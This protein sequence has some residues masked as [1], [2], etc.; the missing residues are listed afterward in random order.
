MFEAAFDLCQP[1]PLVLSILSPG[2]EQSSALPYST[3]REQGLSL[4]HFTRWLWAGSGGGGI[5]H[6][7]NGYEGCKGGCN[8]RSL[9]TRTHRRQAEHAVIRSCSG[10]MFRIQALCPALSPGKN[11]PTSAKA[12]NSLLLSTD[13]LATLSLVGS[14][15]RVGARVGLSVRQAARARPGVVATRVVLL[16]VEAREQANP[17]AFPPATPSISICRPGQHLLPR[18]ARRFLAC[19]RHGAQTVTG[20]ARRQMPPC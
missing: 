17:L 8:L 4:S 5:G 19:T 11:I 13:M 15:H 3:Q 20:T 9:N 6:C 10:T 2:L 12:H 16:A 1:C 14:T 7:C 18:R